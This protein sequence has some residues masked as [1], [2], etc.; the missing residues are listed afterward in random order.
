MREELDLKLYVDTDPDVRFI[1]RLSRDV[2]DR[3][4]SP[5]SVIDQYLGTVRPMHLA[6]VESSRRFADLIIPEGAHNRVAVDIL[7]TKIRAEFASLT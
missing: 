6:F 3:G 1:R 4:R 7:K 2:Q 5:Q